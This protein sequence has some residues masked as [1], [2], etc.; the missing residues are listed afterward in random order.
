MPII[1]DAHQDLAYNM[2]TFGR[3]YRRSVRETRRLE[4]NSPTIVR[5]GHTLLGWPEYQEGQVAIVFGTIFIL[6]SARSSGVWD[7]L[8]YSNFAEAKELIWQQIDLYTHLTE[9]NPQR[10]LLVRSRPDLDRVLDIWKDD[11]PEEP[12]SGYPVGIVLLMEGAEGL[13]NIDDLEG[14]WQA[15]V[16]IVGPVWAG[17]RFCGGSHYPGEFTAEGYALL[18]RMAKLGFTLDVSHMNGKSVLQ[19]LE[20]Y[21]G[22]VIASH[23]NARALLAGDTGERHL[24]DEA[25]RLLCGRDGVIG[26][27]PYNKFLRTEWNPEDGREGIGLDMLVNHIDH[28]CQIAGDAYHVGLGSDFDG[29]F[30][31]HQVPN[32]IDSIADLQKIVPLLVE[33]GYSSLEVEAI[34]HGNWRRCL[35][36]TLPV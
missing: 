17:D 35:E 29:G 19:A 33:R 34:L 32:G 16:R 11:V 20:F 22:S 1:I 7:Y 30:G 2:L 5:T 18:K 15:G 31:V 10:F 26:V 8:A 36:R 21:Q 12:E 6:P 23:A 27:L 4:E 13:E 14:L 28:V 25:I 9:T 24:T 3:D